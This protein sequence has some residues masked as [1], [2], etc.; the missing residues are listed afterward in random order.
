[1][2]NPNNLIAF[3]WTDLYPPGNGLVEYFTTGNAPNRMLVVNFY[4][5]PFCCDNNPVVTSQLIL[6]ENSNHIE[7]HTDYLTNNGW[8]II[9]MGLENIDG[10]EGISVEGRNA[11]VWSVSTPEGK[12]F[13]P[14]LFDIPGAVFTQTAG[15]PSGSCFPL[16]TTTNV[17]DIDDGLGNISTVSFSVTVEDNEAPSLSCPPDIFVSNNPGMAGAIVN[18]SLNKIIFSQYFTQGQISP[19]AQAW[20]D[21]R[22]SLRSDISYTKLTMKGTFDPVGVSVTN[23]DIIRQIAIALRD[24]VY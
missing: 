2:A 20:T 15:L 7:I 6:Y 12:R 19:H 16:G 9:T 22:T 21:F 4:D 3:A 17:F 11:S 10:S 5:I 13:T 24:G 14:S 1:M 18:F 23:P 8:R